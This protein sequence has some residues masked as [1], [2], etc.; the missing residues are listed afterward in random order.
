MQGAAGSPQ[1]AARYCLSGALARPLFLLALGSVSILFYLQGYTLATYLWVFVPLYG[2]YSGALIVVFRKSLLASPT[3]LAIIVGFAVLFRG[4]VLTS[5]PVLSSDLYRYVW[6]GRV[7]RAGINPYRYPPD[8]EA[9][10]TLRD[11]EIYPQINRPGLTTIYPPVAQMLFA[12]ITTIVPESIGGMKAA[13]VLFDLLTLT[14][15]LRLL[16]TTG[17]NPERVVLY[18]WSP[19]VIFECAGSGHVDALMIPFL[20][21]ALQARLAQRPGIC[22]VMLGLATLIKLYPAVVFPAFHT[23]REWRFPLAFG[24]TLMA[25]YAPYVLGVGSDVLGY[26]P[27]YFGQWEDFNGGIRYGLTVVLMPLTSA[28]RSLALG[29]C[30]AVLFGIAWQLSRQPHRGEWV[31]RA[32]S[33]IAAYLLLIPTTFHPWYVLWLLPFLC[34]SPAWGWLYLSGTISL[35]YVAYTQ[36]Y[37]IVP[38]S[39]HLLELVPCY[40]LLL[41]QMVWQRQPGQVVLPVT[42]LVYPWK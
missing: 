13:I 22:G 35:S 23:R 28:A 26:L 37:P 19:L 3:C 12:L 29:I 5:P 33:I 27:D 38:L 15:L 10:V 14:L 36:N 4:L 2:L 20:L 24:L 16:K 8:A 17:N 1:H 40:L 42:E 7:Q 31:Q 41:A 30:A 21:L 34:V 9:L 39:I 25:G 6:D 32:A 18:A 11:S